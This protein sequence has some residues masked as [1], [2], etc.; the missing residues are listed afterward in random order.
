MKNTVFLIFYFISIYVNSC[1]M[2]KIKEP[3]QIGRKVVYIL[4]TIEEN[5][6]QDYTDNFLSIEVL[7]EL[8][9]NKYVVKNESLRNEMTS[10]LKKDWEV[11]I[12]KHFDN[13]IEK[14]KSSGI[15]WQKIEYLDFVYEVKEKQGIKVIKGELYFKYKDKTFKVDNCSIWDGCEYRIVRIKNLLEK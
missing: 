11:G 7:R 5:K 2:Q 10:I 15:I 12:L 13:L 9:K 1:S 14:G 4:K 8:A 6:R 3:D